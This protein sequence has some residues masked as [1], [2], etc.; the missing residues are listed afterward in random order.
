VGLPCNIEMMNFLSDFGIYFNMLRL[1]SR[2]EDALIWLSSIMRNSSK[3]SQKVRAKTS[4]SDCLFFF[5]L[6]PRHPQTKNGLP[7]P[8]AVTEGAQLSRG[9]QS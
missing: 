7:W 1:S 5:H 6:R 2:K 3:E 4:S 9:T 8:P